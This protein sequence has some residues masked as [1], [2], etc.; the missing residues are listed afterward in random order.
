[1]P[2]DTDP[3][4]TAAKAAF[5]QA[6]EHLEKTV[7]ALLHMIAE[8]AGRPAWVW[9]TREEGEARRKACEAF[10]SLYYEDGQ[11]AGVLERVLGVIG[12]SPETIR[13]A[14]AVNDAKDTLREAHR[15]L[16]RSHTA[17][18]RALASL[19]M[20]RFH[21]LQACRRIHTLDVPPVRVG[22][23]WAYVTTRT[24]ITAG[25]LKRMVMNDPEAKR[26]LDR[27]N[28]LP[29]DEVL[30]IRRQMEPRPQANLAFRTP[31]G[32]SRHTVTTTLPILYPAAHG[33][34]PPII[35]PPPEPAMEPRPP[36]RR[37]MDSA[38]E[39]DPIVPPFHV[40]RLREPRRAR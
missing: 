15:R 8:D 4:I 9:D 19:G 1:M 3:T 13:Q 14:R 12:A 20:G 29:D 28:A 11:E 27:I 22:F 23:T 5:L 39:W 7:D 24:P 10:A 30:I 26:Y 31:S 17:R 36:F 33:D 37:R 16:A 38:V 6:Y 35:S 34:D 25:K 2:K 32:F 18:R 21:P 40:Y